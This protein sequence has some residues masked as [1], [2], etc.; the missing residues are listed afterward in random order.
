MLEIDTPGHTAAIHHSHPEYVACFEAKPWTYY[1]NGKVLHVVALS[2]FDFLQNHQP[3]NFGSLNLLFLTSPK[4]CST[5]L[6]IS[7]PENISAREET[8][9]IFAAIKMT[10]RPSQLW[11]VVGELSAKRWQRSLRTLM[12]L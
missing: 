11:L 8:K 10:L 1:A 12:G 6:L 2:P 3:V 4:R 7:P 9:S 5:L